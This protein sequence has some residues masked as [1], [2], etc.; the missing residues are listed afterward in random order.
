VAKPNVAV[1]SIL[2]LVGNTPMVRLNRMAPEN[3][4][5]IVVKLELL[6]PAKTVKDRIALSMITAAEEEGKLREGMTIVEPTSGNTGIGLAMVAA[7]KGYRLILTMPDT[8]SQERRDLLN[9]YGA[10]LILTPGVLDM[11]GAIDRAREIYEATPDA[12]FM[13]QQ[14]ANPANSSTHELTTGPE[15]LEACGGQV[16]AFVS[17]VGTGGTITGVGEAIREACPDALIIAVEPARSNVLSGGSQ[18]L[19]DIQGIGAGFVPSVLNQDIYDEVICVEDE[20]AIATARRLSREEGILGGISAGANV[21]AAIGI[22]SR[23]GEG[24]RVVT[25][26]CDSGERYFSVQGFIDR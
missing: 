1:D 24:K 3:G 14:F 12:T 8:M 2:S 18:G 7:A 4:A 20:E 25:V 9:S 19:H 23:L 11:T 15:I 26:I 21:F 5:E 6:N 22:S 13:P 16:D 17:G 10:E